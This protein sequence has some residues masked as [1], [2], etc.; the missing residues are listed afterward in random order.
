VRTTRARNDDERHGAWTPTRGRTGAPGNEGAIDDDAAR[1]LRRRALIDAFF[2]G[3][4]D[5]FVIERDA[6]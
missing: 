1:S 2:D 4:E 5:S 6:A 3:M